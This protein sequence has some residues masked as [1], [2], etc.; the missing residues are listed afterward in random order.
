MSKGLSNPET[1]RFL[2]NNIRSS[3]RCNKGNKIFEFYT[4]RY[5]KTNSNVLSA[6]NKLHHLVKIQSWVSS[7]SSRAL[8]ESVSIDNSYLDSIKSNS[9]KSNKN[10]GL[11][12]QSIEYFYHMEQRVLLRFISKLEFFDFIFSKT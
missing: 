7:I 11:S 8:F 5:F 12:F 3:T 4:F 6:V 10:F 2:H 1:Y 9:P